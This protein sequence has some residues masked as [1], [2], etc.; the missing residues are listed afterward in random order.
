MSEWDYGETICE[1]P[2]GMP[3]RV[4]KSG[5][6]KV[7]EFKTPEEYVLSFNADWIPESEIEW[8]A[9]VLSSQLNDLIKLTR[10]RQRNEIR[11]K[12]EDL[13]RSIGITATR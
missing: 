4:R 1:L 6:C 7:I 3:V 2:A 13:L 11:E 9:G 10:L 5:Y 8:F 12:Y